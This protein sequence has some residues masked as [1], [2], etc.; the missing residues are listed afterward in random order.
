MTNCIQGQ[1][2]EKT[3]FTDVFP[4]IVSFRGEYTRPYN[5]SYDEWSDG[6]LPSDGVIKKYGNWDE[7]DKVNLST[8][9]WSES[10][11]N[12]HPEAL[13]QLHWN[14]R[15][16]RN[17]QPGSSDRYFPGHWL[18]FPGS[19]LTNPITGS[20]TSIVVDDLT[21]FSRISKNTGTFK[22]PVL[23]L[24][25]TDEQGNRLW[26]H[27]EFVEMTS[28]DESNNTI[29]VKRAQALSTARSF[30]KGVYVAPMC[31]RLS[32]PGLFDYNWSNL[33]PRDANGKQAS[34]IVLEELKDLMLPGGE[35]EHLNGISFDVLQWHPR[36][37]SVDTNNDGLADGGI[38]NGTNHFRE[39]AFEMQ[40]QIRAVF[41]SDMILTSDSYEII[42]QRA[43]H[44]FNGMES[45]GLVAHNDAFRAF[46][47]TINIYCFWETFCSAGNRFNYI[48]NKI[49][50][51][52]DI[53]NTDNYR[54]LCL[55]T[56]TC[57]GVS[58]TRP[59]NLEPFDEQ[60]AGND[61]TSNWLGAPSGEM[62]RLAQQQPDI[63]SNKGIELPADFINYISAHH[64]TVSK[65]GSTIRVRGNS[66]DANENMSITFDKLNMGQSGEDA[67]IYFEIK[68]NNTLANPRIVYAEAS[69]LP[70]LE[71]T[72][73][74]NDMYNH[75]WG[76][77]TDSDY[78]LISLY[79]RQSGGLQDIT[80]SFEGQDDLS[81][82]QITAHQYPQLLAREFKHGIVLVNPS[83]SPQSFNLKAL[84]P[85]HIFTKIDG[86]SHPD[87]ND[88][89]IIENTVEV[90]P[91]NALFL[92]KEASPTSI[93]DNQKESIRLT[94]SK[95]NRTCSIFN[96]AQPV[97]LQI[98]DISGR[99]L[100]THTQVLP[101]TGVRI[102][103]H[104]KGL[105]IINIQNPNQ[106]HSQ[107]IYL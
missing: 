62:L 42:N 23:L 70:Q 75:L 50:N 19:N 45:E 39:R 6:N 68:S 80:L 26:D 16:H 49:N 81:I 29:Q 87:Y 13:M 1:L 101:G 46:S 72:S 98:Y 22:Y 102:K 33:C 93:N 76:Y 11:L 96:V 92:H 48:V 14:M 91:V 38:L 21:P 104:L 9:Q 41:G 2:S 36:E 25:E 20:S 106:N 107:K 63:L 103:N 66:S 27:Y 34:D 85:G 67:V 4:K 97:T 84:F 12:T 105:Y 74:E 95:H 31:T 47:K 54:R 82:R 78:T 32:N 40:K 59:V 44:L 10:F 53:P 24:V 83:L 64:C 8:Q 56:A 69:N 86:F 99:L 100:E 73:R 35:L 65:Q 88:G 43:I 71:T 51:E 79:Y 17:D 37:S 94:Y 30:A 77:Y 3:V 55:G 57:L 58:M 60:M 28:I 7:M 5:N 61:Q 52:I 89:L 18:S 15:S 90:A